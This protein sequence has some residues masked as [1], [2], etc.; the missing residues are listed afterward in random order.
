MDENNNTSWA[1]MVITAC[2]AVV[3]HLLQ[4]LGRGE[5]FT[6][7]AEALRRLGKAG[8]VGCLSAGAWSLLL[9]FWPLSDSAAVAVAVGV[10]VLGAEFAEKALK[11]AANR[12]LEQYGGAVKEKE[13][14][15]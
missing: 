2:I 4:D 12:R 1:L 9:Q 15:E 6:P 8:W 10:T 11:Q 7:Q 3:A 5:P 13:E 14:N